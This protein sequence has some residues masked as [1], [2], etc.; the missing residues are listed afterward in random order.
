MKRY[1]PLSF[2]RLQFVFVITS[3]KIASLSLLEHNNRKPNFKLDL[4]A[5]VKR[6]CLHI[7]LFHRMRI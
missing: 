4:D 3:M 1:V 7:P 6:I 2:E 5:S